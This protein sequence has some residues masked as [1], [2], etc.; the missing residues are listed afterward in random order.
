MAPVAL[1]TGAASGI[2]AACVRQLTA[3]G[4]AVVGLD[5]RN[6][7]GC[8]RSI[9]LDVS[10]A[11]AVEAAFTLV[12]REHGPVEAVV[13]AAGYYERVDILDLDEAALD[14]IVAVL[15]NGTANVCRSAL[16]RMLPRG[17]G[18]IC[19]IGSELGLCGDA[20]A[21][22]YA[23]CKG[24]VHSLTKTLAREVA[25]R[26]IRVNC[27]APGP[28]DTP[29]M[30]AEMR[31]PAYIASLVLQRLVDPNEIAAMVGFVLDSDGHNLVGQIISPNAGAVV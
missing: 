17:H 22:H 21:A 3:D 2:G 7:D 12:E 30:T 19:T 26:G 20:D 18:S 8:D 11:D 16:R 29:L 4:F 5:L 14:R 6:V 25:P 13:T 27:V 1:V 15:I 9:T 23:A 28:T 24:A 31:D 10:D